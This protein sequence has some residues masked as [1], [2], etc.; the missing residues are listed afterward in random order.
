MTEREEKEKQYKRWVNRK[1][2][3]IEIKE[4]QGTEII[5]KF[6]VLCFSSSEEAEH[7]LLVHNY[8]EALKY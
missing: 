3:A 7:F 8:T 1:H 4:T 2:V 5:G 6:G